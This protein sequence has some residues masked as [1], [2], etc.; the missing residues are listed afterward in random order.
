M[1][2]RLIGCFVM[3]TMI[4]SLWK[5]FGGETSFVAECTVPPIDFELIRMMFWVEQ[6]CGCSLLI[7]V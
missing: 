2:D 7:D 1:A 4:N 3:L 6:E 5:S